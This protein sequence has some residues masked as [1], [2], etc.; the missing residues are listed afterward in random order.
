M[1]YD[2]RGQPIEIRP[3]PGLVCS[4]CRYDNTPYMGEAPECCEGCGER[5]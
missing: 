1:M 2:S 3:D 5:L 4:F